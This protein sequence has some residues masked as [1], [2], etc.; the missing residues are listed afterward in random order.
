MITIS[1]T[2][3]IMIC[4]AFSAPVGSGTEWAFYWLETKD[5]RL[6]I[7]SEGEIAGVTLGADK[8]ILPVTAQTTLAGCQVDG[9]AHVT[10]LDKGGVEIK[11]HFI[12]QAGKERATLVE[13][14]RP[15]KNSIRWELEV[16]SNDNFW[17]TSIETQWNWPKVQESSFWTTWGD[18]RP[19]GGGWADPLQPQPWS[20]REFLYGGHSYF[21]EPGT[22]S[23]PVA[24]ILAKKQDV[25]LSLVLSP[26]DLILTMKMWTTKN[27]IVVFSREYLRLGRGKVV[28]FALDI[29]AHPADWRGGIGW[30]VER[31][32]GYFNPPN[33]HVQQMAGCGSYS[34]HRDITDAARL[35]RMAYRVNWK[36]SYDFPFMGMFLPPVESDTEEWVDFKSQKNSIAQMRAAAQDLRGQGFHLLNYFN[37]TELGAHYTWPPPPR[38]ASRDEDLW[39][40]SNDFLFYAMGDAILPNADGKPIGSWTGCV[41]MD[42]GEKAYQEHLIEQ[43][44]RHVEKFPE[45]S[46]ICIDRLDWIWCYNRQRDDGVTWFE[47]K[48]ARSLVVSWLGLMDRLGPVM[49]NAGKVIYANP[50]YARLDLMKAVDGFYDEHGQHPTSLNACCL[51]AL[52]KPIIAWTWELE[53]FDSD[54]DAYFQRHLHMGCFL[55]APVAGNDHTILPD[56]KRDQ[57]YYDYGPL[58]DALRGKRWV[59]L[60]HVIE[61]KDGKALA[62]LFEVPGGYVGPVTF[63]GAASSVQILL[64]GLPALPGQEEFRIMAILPGERDPVALNAVEKYGQWRIDVPLKR[65]CAMLVLKNAWMEPGASYFYDSTSVKLDST[66][67]EASWHYTLDG[68]EPTEKLAIYEAPIELKETTVVKAAAFR[69]KEK[70]GLVLEREYVRRK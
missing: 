53:L 6:C 24:T 7:T 9:S 16:T 42:A 33:P 32:P 27:G 35:M 26:E 63:G 50:M 20:D 46:G 29:V 34:S 69:G 25:G 17:S 13:Q 37:V 70:V 56:P 4:L 8:D 28:R 51:L 47:N 57:Y 31:Y 67:K 48:P 38:K 18:P 59:L 39:K 11:K 5:M 60:P 49:H 68:S 40:D 55:T 61:V 62:N 23:L 36:A 1:R 15:C 19:Q 2:L 54:T 3:I 44:K 21:K 58:L 45:S 52:S 22:F 66:V 12:H 65:G 43:A 14:F 30:L 10:S 41:V 64:Q